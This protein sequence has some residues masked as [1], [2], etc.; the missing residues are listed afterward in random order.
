MLEVPDQF[1]PF[2]VFID[3]GKEIEVAL[4]IA[5]HA[6]KILD[7]KKAQI[8]V[9]ILDAFLL[10]LAALLGGEFVFFAAFGGPDGAALVINELG[11][12]I[13]RTLAI[14]PAFHLHLEE[15]EVDPKLQFFPAIE[16]R[17]FPDL[18]RASFM[19]PVF[20]QAV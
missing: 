14:G 8:A 16:A 2:A 11:L 9:V 4:G 7:L 1:L 19:R 17:N 10:Q 5:N 13:V 12:A 15:A 3:E 6:L 18:D 20:Q